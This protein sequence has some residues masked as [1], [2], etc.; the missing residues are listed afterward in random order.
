MLEFVTKSTYWQ[1]LDDGMEGRLAAARPWWLRLT[2]RGRPTWHLKSVQDVMALH[3]LRD[4]HDKDIAEIGGGDSRVLRALLS[5]NRCVNIE[6]FEGQDGGPEREVSIRGVRNVSAFIGEFSLQLE[7]CA[8]DLLFSVSV[9]EHVV[10][11]RVDEFIR[12]CHRLLKPGGRMVHLVDMYLNPQRV[13]YN[14]GRIACYL[15]AFDSGLFEAEADVRIRSTADLTFNESYCTNPD[16]IMY[17]WSQVAPALRELREHS[18][19]VAIA[20]TGRKAA[21]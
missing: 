15:S 1:C 11:N 5:A 14:A 8:Y 21:I 16:N 10:N 9:V 2:H 20:W 7:D 4:P 6:K 17:G 3:Y 13:S 19:S 18:Q 12:D